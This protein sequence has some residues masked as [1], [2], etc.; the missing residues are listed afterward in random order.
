MPADVIRLCGLKV[1]AWIGVH[2]DERRQPQSLVLTVELT[3][4][5]GLRDLGDDL[6]RT[7]DYTAVADRI[8][9][10]ALAQKRRLIETLAEETAD[11]LLADYPLREAT[12]EVRK[13][14]L[15]CC[16][17]VAVRVTRARAE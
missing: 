8:R 5:R 1:P 4:A 14:V 11:A 2:A 3:P 17:H 12:V 16:D 13:F 9:S 15:P 7:I 10:I 6:G